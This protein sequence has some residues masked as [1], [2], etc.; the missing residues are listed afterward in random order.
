MN[1]LS[2]KVV[3]T[4]GA[5]FIGSHIVDALVAQ[6]SCEVVVVDDLSTGSLD[7]LALSQSAITFE[8]G[9]ITDHAFLSRVCEGASYVFHQAAIASV[10]QSI[11]DPM[12]THAVNVTGTL[13]VLEAARQAGVKRVVYASSSAVYGDTQDMP[14]AEGTSPKPLSPYATH[15][16]MNELYAS[17][18]TTLYGLETVGLRYFNVFGNRQSPDSAYAAVVPLFKQA[19]QEGRQP[20]IFGDGESSSRDYVHVADVVQANI[21]ACEAHDVVGSVYNVGTGHTT[22]PHQ[23]LQALNTALNTHITPTYQPY[24]TGEILTSV[25]D[26]QKAHAELGYTP[27]LSLEEGIRR[28]CAA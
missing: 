1:A 2:G 15:K 22:T 18:Y 10:Q 20:T 21:K 16:Y 23:L 7:N 11:D 14:L 6:R 19:L 26:I 3:V 27:T 8:N 5:G 25:A 13:N 24:R 28:M 4:G 12:H 9:S 17:L